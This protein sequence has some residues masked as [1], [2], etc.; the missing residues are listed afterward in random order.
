MNIKFEVY[1][2]EGLLLANDLETLLDLVEAAGY[3]VQAIYKEQD[4][5]N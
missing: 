5:E 3:K 4:H 1:N 2:D